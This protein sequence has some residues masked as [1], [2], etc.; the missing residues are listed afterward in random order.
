LA[1]EGVV[2]VAPVRGGRA[3]GAHRLGL[4]SLTT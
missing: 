4:M 1:G 2:R 3:N